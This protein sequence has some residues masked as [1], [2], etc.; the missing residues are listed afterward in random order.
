MRDP[1]KRRLSEKAHYYRHHDR[2]LADRAKQ[3]KA[4]LTKGLCEKCGKYP[5]T[6][7][8]LCRSCRTKHNACSLVIKWQHKLNGLCRLCSNPVVPG[9]SVCFKHLELN[10]IMYQAKYRQD[11]VDGKCYEC[12]RGLSGWEIRNGKKRCFNCADKRRMK[13]ANVI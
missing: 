3:K 6:Q 11:M 1:V 2:I 5:N 12:S 7:G 8:K 13:R 4:R 9:Y 10:R